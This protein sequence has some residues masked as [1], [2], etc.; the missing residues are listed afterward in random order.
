MTRDKAENLIKERE[1]RLGF[2]S[3]DEVVE[4]LQLQPHLVRTLK[5]KAVI[6][7]YQSQN[8]PDNKDQRL[9]DF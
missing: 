7:T 4:F 3:F 9:I 2:S 1:R 5:A 6:L 8:V